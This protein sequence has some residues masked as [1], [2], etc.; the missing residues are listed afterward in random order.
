MAPPILVGFSGLRRRRF[1]QLCCR[2][3]GSFLIHCKQ[4]AVL[5]PV[6]QG[7]KVMLVTEYEHL[8]Q[9]H[10]LYNILLDKIHQLIRPA[11]HHNVFLYDPTHP[12][13]GLSTAPVD[14][15]AIRASL[16]CILRW[17]CIF[18]GCV[19]YETIEKQ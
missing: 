6:S 15:T 2:D 19:L 18:H 7:T 8:K 4:D 17:M 3:I 12:I 1:V 10:I 5:I 14:I 11:I 16:L 9:A 13:R